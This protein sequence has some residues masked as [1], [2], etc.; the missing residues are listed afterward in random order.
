MIVAPDTTALR[1]HIQGIKDRSCRIA[2]VPTM[3]NLHAGHLA[4][5]T[6]AQA[7]ADAVVVSIFVNPMQFAAR[8]DLYT[9][10]RTLD[11]DLAA[12]E[13]V[14]VDLVFTPTVTDVYPEGFEAHTAIQ[15]PVL[16]DVLCGRERPGHFVGVC[17]VVYK[18]FEMVEPDV[19]VFGEKDLQQLLIIKKMVNDLNLVIDI[20]SGPTQRAADGLALSS[21]NQYLTAEERAIAPRLWETLQ[22]CAGELRSA[23]GCEGGSILDVARV[24]LEQ[25]GFA[26]DYLELRVLSTLA[27]SDSLSEDCALFVAAR[28]G[29]TRLIDNIQIAAL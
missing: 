1:R 18:L 7:C 9:Y 21:R 27:E 25:E 16:G 15:V 11:A 29:Q 4:L 20:Q 12:L 13:L 2:F 22:A 8:E 17:T 28:L 23:A 5:V 14:G 10:P 3:G 26:V 6:Q 24:S 19:A